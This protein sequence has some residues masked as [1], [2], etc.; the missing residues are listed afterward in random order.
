MDNNVNFIE[1]LI[2]HC[3]FEASLATC[4]D[5]YNAYNDTKHLCETYLRKTN[6]KK[7]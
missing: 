7:H 1:Q 2:E 3:K 5:A 4:K 6:D